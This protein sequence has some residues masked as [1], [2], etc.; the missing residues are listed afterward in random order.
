MNPIKVLILTGSMNLGG[1]ETQMM[2]LLRNADPNHFQI[3]FTSTLPDPYYRREIEGLGSKCPHL[4]D[5]KW[6]FPPAAVFLRWNN[7]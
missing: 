5:M 2:H 4:P 7:I 6:Y 1:I 3:D